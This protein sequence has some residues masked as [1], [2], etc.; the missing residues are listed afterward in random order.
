MDDQ[1]Y[2]DLKTIPL[3]DY[4]KELEQ[5][6][7]IPSRMILKEDIK[8]RFAC[9][10]QHGINTLNDILVAF[11]TPEKLKAFS[12]KSGLPEEFLVILKREIASSQPKP[13]TLSDFPGIARD[14]I[15][16]LGALG[17]NNTKQLFPLI[18]TRTDRE[19]LGEKTG[20]TYE[21]ILELTKLTDV[22]RIKW[23]GANFARMLV[24][25]EYNTVE[26]VSK[27]DYSKLY[28]EINRI[29]AE[30]Q[31]FKGKFGLNDMK[32]CVLAAKNV[33]KVVIYQEGE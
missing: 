3:F 30:K 18:I 32:L 11:K 10:Q 4:A 26:K 20:I 23:V 28:T 19:L 6:E 25:A 13:V 12:Q 16:K 31:F 17:V 14:V 1:Y 5:T 8:Q 22:S 2:I 21:V 29:N 24:D 33:P 15:Q 7:L 27:A 9:L